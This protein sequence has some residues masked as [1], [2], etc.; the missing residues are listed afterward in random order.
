M[1]R[2]PSGTWG[3]RKAFNL[4]VL[5]HVHTSHM[6]RVPCIRPHAHA[7]FIRVATRLEWGVDG[8]HL[9]SRSMSSAGSVAKRACTSQSGKK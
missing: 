6:L 5:A 4:S 9:Q 2:P 3:R 1:Q 7:S 8:A